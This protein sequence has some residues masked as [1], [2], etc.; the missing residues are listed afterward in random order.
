MHVFLGLGQR[1]GTLS[2][3]CTNVVKMSAQ[4]IILFISERVGNMNMSMQ[5]T[6]EAA[7]SEPFL[8]FGKSLVDLS[9]I[10]SILVEAGAAR[11]AI[12][13]GFPVGKWEA[14]LTEFI[15]ERVKACADIQSVQVALST[16]IKPHRVQATL[17]S[18]PNIKNIIAVAS[19]K[20]GVGKSTTA[21][22]V[23]L[24][25]SQNGARVGLLDADI[26]GPNQ[27]HMLGAQAK[28]LLNDD[29][30]MLPVSVHGIQTMSIGYLVDVETPMVWRGPMVSTALQQLFQD[31]MWDALDYLIVDLPPGTGDV[32]LTLSKKIPLT[33]ALV[34]TTPQDI[35][36]LDARKA[37]EMFNKV[38]VS[39][40]GVVENMS[41]HTCTACGHQAPIFG[42]HGA[43]QLA[44]QYDVP[45]LGR[46][47]LALSIREAM[48]KGCPPVIASPE[49]SVAKAYQA[50]ALRLS[51]SLARQPRDYGVNFPPVVVE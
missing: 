33:G 20:G 3:R 12:Q 29:K 14:A 1:L 24:A 5:H 9:A 4:Q 2:T 25:L 41:T 46:L 23:A 39:I 44:A 21:A 11:I 28:P 48:D 50:I 27:P 13:L 16:K 19:G 36:L 32:Q 37:I 26:Y 43:Q 17:K 47:P 8:P 35:A 30:K 38:H 10:Q 42:E 34:V 15:V 31:T 49:S 45:L 6:I 22:N 7:L 51:I 18:L 40:L